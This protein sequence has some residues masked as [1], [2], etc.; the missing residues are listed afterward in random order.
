[1]FR[2]SERRQLG[3]MM[4]GKYFPG[5]PTWFPASRGVSIL[6]FLLPF[7]YGGPGTGVIDIAGQWIE[8]PGTRPPFELDFDKDDPSIRWVQRETL[9]GL[10]R[11][12]GSCLV[13]P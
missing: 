5:L 12:D 10:A 9:W 6:S 11:A 8:P 13:E 3:G 7:E 4:D 1:R 2:V